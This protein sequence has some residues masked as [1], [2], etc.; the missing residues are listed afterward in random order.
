MPRPCSLLVNRD[1]PKLAWD[2]SPKPF[3]SKKG[4]WDCNLRP[5][6]WFIWGL[7]VKF[8]GLFGPKKASNC[9]KVE[10]VKLY[11]SKKTKNCG[12]KWPHRQWIQSY[13]C[14]GLLSW[15]RRRQGHEVAKD[16]MCNP[17]LGARTINCHQDMSSKTINVRQCL[18]D[19][20][21]Q[22]NRFA[23]FGPTHG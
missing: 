9:R 7:N 13:T 16:Q 4:D 8:V 1:N 2:C 10:H 6:Y 12:G 19:E 14:E 15:L 18:C 20:L 5:F 3:F 22:M 21:Q 17:N 23:S 11:L